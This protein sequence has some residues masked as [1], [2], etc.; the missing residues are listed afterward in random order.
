MDNSSYSPALI[1]AIRAADKKYPNRVFSAFD[2]CFTLHN[3]KIAFIVDTYG[4]RRSAP[5]F[6]GIS[7]KETKYL[8]RLLK[9]FDLDPDEMAE[10]LWS[11]Y[12][13]SHPSEVDNDEFKEE[14]FDTSDLSEVEEDQEN[15]SISSA[16]ANLEE[17]VESGESHYDSMNELL[18]SLFRYGCDASSIYYP[19]EDVGPIDLAENTLDSF[20]EALEFA[21]EEQWIDVLKHA[22]KYLLSPRKYR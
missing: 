15:Y 14:I 22:N 2:G 12:P 4:F 9:R 11:V 7:K 20:D 3:D 10:K 1:E 13:Y 18:D 8:E 19:W 5:L 21:T 16:Y 17:Y 6:A